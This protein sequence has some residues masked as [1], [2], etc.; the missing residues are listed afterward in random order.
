MRRF[1]SIELPRSSR[2]VLRRVRVPACLLASPPAEAEADRDGALLLDIEIADGKLG[3]IAPSA[4]VAP[5]AIPTVDLAGRHVWPTLV[6]VH[7]HLDKCH[8][9][10]RTQNPAGDFA[11]ARD[12]TST[13]RVR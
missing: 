3:A 1:A 5:D 11:G 6:D 13:D 9:I 12:G 4:P 10:D 7:T 2:Y 8:I